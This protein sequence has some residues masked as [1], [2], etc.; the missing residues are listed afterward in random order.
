MFLVP[1]SLLSFLRKYW[2]IEKIVFLKYRLY[3]TISDF[4]SLKE[5]M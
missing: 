3:I 5:H 4:Q 2:E 1:K